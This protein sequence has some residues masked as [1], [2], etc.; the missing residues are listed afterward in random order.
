MVSV[1]YIVADVDEAV[2]FYRN[3]L[4]FKLDKHNPGKFATT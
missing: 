2:A 4:D 3:H 1:R